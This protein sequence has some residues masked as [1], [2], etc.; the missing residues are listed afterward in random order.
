MVGQEMLYSFLQQYRNLGTPEFNDLPASLQ[1]ATEIHQLNE[2][3]LQLLPDLTDVGGRSM[4]IDQ[5]IQQLDSANPNSLNDIF[6]LSNLQAGPTADPLLSSASSGGLYSSLPTSTGVP[7]QTAGGN[8]AFDLT[9]SPEA[10]NAP[11][12]SL[13]PASL[14][15]NTSMAFDKNG[16]IISYPVQASASINP[17]LNDLA[18]GTAASS[19]ASSLA[20]K[21][22]LPDQGDVLGQQR[23]PSLS[24]GVPSVPD[25]ALAARPLAHPRGY[26]GAQVA[27]QSQNGGQQPPTSLYSQL[28][29]PVQLQQAQ[30]QQ[31]AMAQSLMNSNPYMLQSQRAPLPSAQVM[32]PAAQQAHLNTLMAYRAMG[33]QCKAPEDKEA[34]EDDNAKEVSLEEWLDAEKLTESEVAGTSP[35][36]AVGSR[37]SKTS[38]SSAELLPTPAASPAAHIDEPELEDAEESEETYSAN[39]PA[40]K[41]SVLVQKS[42]TKMRAVKQQSLSASQH[43]EPVSYLRQ[44]TELVS[45]KTAPAPPTAKEGANSNSERQQLLHVAAQLLVRINML[46]IKKLREQ[47]KPAAATAAVDDNSS[48][49]ED[50]FDEELNA[51]ENE[52]D[53]L[54]LNSQ[55]EEVSESTAPSSGQDVD[56]Q[57][58]M[59]D[60]LAKL[61]LSSSHQSTINA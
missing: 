44:R 27:P 49:G 46:Y 52:L 22:L 50:N 18:N 57:Q 25:S 61:S 41:K 45:Q 26:R 59:I 43:D 1:S 23:L 29:T 34:E 21:A 39:H 12:A 6:M 20:D 10:P 54:N 14:P 8:F 28:Y 60:R 24:P 9:A 51:L 13:G 5:L 2:G 33:L 15:L 42:R 40:V 30:L 58:Q 47:N 16:N 7:T 32:D 11:L 19:S 53:A 55:N 37:N 4:F 3:L 56:K 38:P 48:S 36:A 35:V 17:T 31:K